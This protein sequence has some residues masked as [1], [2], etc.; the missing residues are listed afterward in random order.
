MLIVI[1]PHK[2]DLLKDLPLV[3]II[4]IILPTVLVG[5]PNRA[6]EPPFLHVVWKPYCQYQN[7]IVS[8]LFLT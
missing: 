5:L 2:R 6:P 3:F 8:H 1:L 7:S 4:I